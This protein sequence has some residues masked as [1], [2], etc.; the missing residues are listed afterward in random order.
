MGVLWLVRQHPVARERES[1]LF[2]E[3]NSPSTHQTATPRGTF[4]LAQAVV[5]CV[6]PARA[7]DQT[8]G[9][10][11]WAW[12]LHLLGSILFLDAMSD[13]VFCMF[14]PC[15]IDLDNMGGYNWASIVMSFLYIV[16]CEACRRM[17][18]IASLGGC[19]Y[20]LQLWMWSYLPLGHSIEFAPSP[21]FDVAEHWLWSTAAYRWVCKKM[22]PEPFGLI[23][24]GVW[25]ST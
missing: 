8:I 13:I 9:Y 16:V 3:D 20:L 15:L 24:F 17:A 22:D 5:R 2:L 7:D 12:V 10:Y 18:R 6:C 25:W 4:H 21:W 11:Y 19:V 23:D 14:L 1:M